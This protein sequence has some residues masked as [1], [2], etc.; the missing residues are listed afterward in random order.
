MEAMS[1]IL[2]LSSAYVVNSDIERMQSIF[3]APLPDV[4]ALHQQLG[5]MVHDSLLYSTRSLS[6]S[7]E[8]L[9]GRWNVLY[10]S[11]E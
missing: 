1:G 5:K 9:L 3:I 6:Y 8:K 7:I 4:I 11:G 2:S 10:I